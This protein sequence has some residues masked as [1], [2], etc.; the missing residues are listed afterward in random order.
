VFEVCSRFLRGRKGH[1]FIGLWMGMVNLH[2]LPFTIRF[3]VN[4]D[5][6]LYL[7]TYQNLGSS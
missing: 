7:P 2:H 3:L 6:G 1:Y 4:L 5:C